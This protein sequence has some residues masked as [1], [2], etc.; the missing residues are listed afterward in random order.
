MKRRLFSTG[1]LLFS[2]LLAPALSQAV[3]ITGNASLRGQTDHSGIKALFLRIAPSALRDSTLT[4]AAGHYSISLQTGIY[5]VTFSKDGYFANTLTER[6]LYSSQT[7]PNVTLVPLS[8]RLL[9]PAD[10]STIQSAIDAS[11]AA[12]TV[13]V[14]PGRYLE[15]IN[16]KGKNIVVGSLFLTTGDT[17][18]V[19]NT[20]IDG[21][22]NG[23]VVEFSSGEDS[24]A[25]LCGLTITNGQTNGDYPKGQGGGI[26]CNNASP[27]LD[28]LIIKKNIA[29]NGGGGLY[30]EYGH[31]VL[32]N[33]IISE[34]TATVWGGGIESFYG[35]ILI[36]NVIV[37]GNKASNGYG[38]GIYSRSDTQLRNVTV[39]N[40]EAGVSGGGICGDTVSNF[41]ISNCIISFNNGPYS[42]YSESGII[43]IRNSDIYKSTNDNFYNC[44]NIVGKNVTT[45]ANGDSC[46][47]YN[48]IQIDPQFVDPDH[49]DFRLRDTSP[50]IGAGT[51]ENAPLT[52]ILGVTRGN[53][54]DMGAYENA[55]DIPAAVPFFLLTSPNGGEEWIAWRTNTITWKSSGVSTVKLEYSKDNGST[56]STI[57][58]SVNAADSAYAWTIPDFPSARCLVRGTDT[59]NGA[60]TDTS[61]AAFTILPTPFLRLTAPNGGESWRT[62]ANRYITWESRSVQRV[63]VEYT[64]NGGANW[65][66]LTTDADASL[67][68]LAWTLPDSVSTSCL[69]R[70]SDAAF[71]ALTDISEAAFSILAHNA[72][73]GFLV[74][75]DLEHA[76]Y[77]GLDSIEK[78]GGG[79]NVGFALYANEWDSAG[80]FTVTFSWDPDKVSFRSTSSQNI[81]DDEVTING[82]TFTPAPE[83]NILGE[84]LISAGEVNSPGF[85]TRSF[86]VQGSGTVIAPDGLIYFAVFRTAASFAEWDTLSIRCDVRMAD[87]NGVETQLQTKYFGIVPGLQPPSNFTVSDVPNDQG[88]SLRLNWTV[89][90]SENAGSVGWYRI[91]RSR[92]NVMTDPIP[93]T[94]FASAD[95][96]NAWDQHATILVDSV[97]AGKTTYLDTVLLS[98]VTYYYWI[99]AVGSSGASKLIPIG[100]PTLVAAGPLEFCM[101][102]PFPNPFN[103]TTTIEFTIP[104]S[105]TAS[106]VIYDASG[107]K[108]RE[109][110][111]GQVSAGIRNVLWNGRDDSGRAVSSGV[112]FA[113]LLS[114]KFTAVRKMLLIK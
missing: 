91:F 24:T 49:G 23:H 52:D 30:N 41:T 38:G 54:P 25:V 92:S 57:A 106:L 33:T 78:I 82:A 104:S 60:L 9:V 76:G 56:W 73:A 4:D 2:L 45:T 80:G 95:S 84:N 47:A 28:N 50:C 19:S 65:T 3:T 94:R 40:N 27:T 31:P 1:Y 36:D 100:K 110:V 58:A 75:A 39:S 51:S 89:S 98:G 68:K 14:S 48:N 53:P 67:G 102:E 114:G 103:P 90:P 62:T 81:T 112:Y 111:S 20:I 21:N 12:D 113:R 66:V 61:D 55:R 37:Y 93:I 6:S 42:V 16:F 64:L 13:L 71:P 101:G 108:V 26:Y 10:F 22:Q 59:V 35:S 97:S 15:N 107:R 85:Y 87:T 18:Y 99:Q 86:A 79:K 29:L 88:H 32:K 34:N 96:L 77:Q 5:T 43:I 44:G 17:T 8:T 11:R 70:I 109:L 83:A 7:L 63:K 72:T 105:G 69:V 74:D 46:D